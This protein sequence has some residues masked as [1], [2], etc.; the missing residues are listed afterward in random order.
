MR[1]GHNE[2]TRYSRKGGMLRRKEHA[3]KI[4]IHKFCLI[5]KKKCGKKDIM[6]IK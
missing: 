3:Q 4:S 6:H 2:A 5:A 1:K